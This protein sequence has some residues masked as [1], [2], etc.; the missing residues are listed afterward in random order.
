MFSINETV[1][2]IIFFLVL[3]QKSKFKIFYLK[4][5]IIFENQYKKKIMLKYLIWIILSELI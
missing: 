3:I 2:K 5:N 1:F 4:K